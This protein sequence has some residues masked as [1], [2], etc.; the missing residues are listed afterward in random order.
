M[1]KEPST[2][3]VCDQLERAPAPEPAGSWVKEGMDG[4]TASH[5]ALGL[6]PILAYLVALHQ[7]IWASTARPAASPP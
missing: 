4:L 3:C 6:L 5:V 1:E 7:M 2:G